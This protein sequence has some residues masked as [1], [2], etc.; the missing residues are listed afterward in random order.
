MVLLESLSVLPAKLTAVPTNPGV[1]TATAT[2]T[3]TAI[4]A[5]FM[6]MMR[7]LTP[8]TIAM[9]GPKKL[10][11]S[12]IA[13]LQ[14]TSLP[15]ELLENLTW[16]SWRRLFSTPNEKTIIRECEQL[17]T[18]R[19]PPLTLLLIRGWPIS[20]GRKTLIIDWGED[21]PLFSLL[22]HFISLAMYDDAFE[23]TYAKSVENMFRVQI[24][25]GKKSLTLKWKCRVL[26]L[27]VFREPLR[28]AG[29][30]G[31]SSTTSLRANTWIRHLKRLG[32]KASF[33]HSF[34]QYG[35][36]RGLLN[37]VNNT[38][39]HGPPLLI[40]FSRIVHTLITCAINK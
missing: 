16:S 27:P 21:D 32:Q 31:T 22:D 23:A 36:R 2:A 20:L 35:L 11:R 12:C 19:S 33:E 39:A 24:P 30:T 17:C 15:T 37:V 28:G 18:P 10:D 38:F 1:V 40:C 26:N 25:P 4:P 7:V 8:M 5:R 3:A 29:G 6:A 9:Q 14:S 34:T 13:I